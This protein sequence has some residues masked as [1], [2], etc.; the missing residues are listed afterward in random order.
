MGRKDNEEGYGIV[1]RFF[2]KPVVAVLSGLV[3]ATISGVV[4]NQFASASTREIV[5]KAILIQLTEELDLRE[6]NKTLGQAIGNIKEEK[7][8]LS[9]EIG[10]LEKELKEKDKTIADLNDSNEISKLQDTVDELQQKI[11]AYRYNSPVVTVDGNEVSTNSDSVLMHDGHTYYDDSILKHFFSDEMITFQDNKLDFNTKNSLVTVNPQLE[12]GVDLLTMDVLNRSSDI[13]FSS[14]TDNQG[15]MHSSA[16]G[17]DYYYSGTGSIEFNLDK[18]YHWF[19]CSVFVVKEAVKYSDDSSVWENAAIKIIGNQ[20]VLWETSAFSRDAE[21]QKSDVIDVSGCKRIT[22]KFY[23]TTVYDYYGT[24]NG[25]VNILS[26]GE[27]RL[28][29][30]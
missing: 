27:P 22:I 28:Y 30:D 6:S 4:V 20:T 9:M 14:A 26:V 24:H 15:V 2:T 5:E 13:V 11:D 17:T 23:N 1:N 21:N 19:T 7:E 10:N 25:T 29:T 16:V 18:K 3:F 8:S 12:N